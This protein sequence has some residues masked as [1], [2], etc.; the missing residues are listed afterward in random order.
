MDSDRA[1]KHACHRVRAVATAGRAFYLGITE[2]PDRRFGE[3]LEANPGWA[4]MNVLVQAPSSRHTA[5]LEMC[6]LVTYGPSL[7]CLNKSAGGER[8][9]SG[10]PHYLYML[11]ADN[12]LIRH[13]RA[14]L[15]SVQW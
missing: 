10:T 13:P 3:H 14:Q 15:E 9:S 5:A 2:N 6:L 12:G 4:Y 7:Q 11:V 1:Y 8:A